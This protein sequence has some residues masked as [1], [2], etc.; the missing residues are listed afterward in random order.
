MAIEQ[1]QVMP[2]PKTAA[3][4]RTELAL[5]AAVLVPLHAAGIN[6]IVGFIVAHHACNVDK[7]GALLVVPT[8]DLL[9]AVGSAVLA[10]MLRGRFQRADDV[11]PENG[12]RLF[13]AN[14]GLLLSA[15]CALIILG[16]LAATVILSPCD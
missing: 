4:R 8:I 9:L 15:L 13:M 10:A 12:R 6:T 16:G 7:K 11:Q 14:L 2:P 3:D 5:W 1:H